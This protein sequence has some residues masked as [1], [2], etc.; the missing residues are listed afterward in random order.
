MCG[1]MLVCVLRVACC[2]LR[3]ACCVLRVCVGVCVCVVCGRDRGMEI[4]GRRGR[5]AALLRMGVGDIFTLTTSVS[6]FAAACVDVR[7]SL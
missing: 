2:V 7:C 6:V 1:D 5:V 4:G 3:V